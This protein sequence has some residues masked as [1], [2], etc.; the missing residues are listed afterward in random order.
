MPRGRTTDTTACAAVGLLL[1]LVAAV[2]LEAFVFFAGDFLAGA[3]FDFTDATEPFLFL[4][5]T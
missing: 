5:F 2:L 3:F 4:V 1:P